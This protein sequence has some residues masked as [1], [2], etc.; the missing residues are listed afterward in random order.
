MP[1]Q[2]FQRPVRTVAQRLRLM[3]IPHRPYIGRELGVD[4][5]TGT[6]VL[7]AAI[8]SIMHR[9]KEALYEA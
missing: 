7:S 5:L 1:T 6:P 8:S 2:N 3:E 9:G 4:R